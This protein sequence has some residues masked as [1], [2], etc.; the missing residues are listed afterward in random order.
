MPP[1]MSNSKD[2]QG[3][4][5]KYLDTSTKTSSQEILVC[6]MEAQIFIILLWI[7]FIF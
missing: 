1:I 3:H 5:D 2:G 4:K 6:N 7:T